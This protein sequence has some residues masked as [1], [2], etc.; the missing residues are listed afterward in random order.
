METDDVSQKFCEE[1][2][3]QILERRTRVVKHLDSGNVF[4]KA[5]FQVDEDIDDPDFWDNLLSKKK[6][7]ED[8][9]RV[10]RQMRR[11]ARDGD[12]HP[13]EIEEIDGLIRDMEYEICETVE[14]TKEISEELK[15][16]DSVEK[17]VGDDEGIEKDVSSDIPG[18]VTED[19]AHKNSADKSAEGKVTPL[20]QQS[21]SKSSSIDDLS[22]VPQQ[23]LLVF[24]TAL[25][26]GIPTINTLKNIKE[27]H[28]VISYVTKYC[29]EMTERGKVREDFSLHLE[30]L[31]KD[32]REIDRSYFEKYESVY[33]K[34]YERYLLRVQSI[35]IL[36][37]LIKHED[38]STMERG[39]GWTSEDDKRV[40]NWVTSNGYDNYP[41]S[42]G[43]EK[44]AFRGKSSHELN[45]RVR[46]IILTLNKKKDVKK[47]DS[48]IRGAILVFGKVTDE[49]RDNVRT[50]LG[51]D[52]SKMEEVE[53]MI[54]EALRENTDADLINRINLLS[55]LRELDD[56]P[57]LRRMAGLPRRW[58]VERDN[59]L[60]E[61]VIKEGLQE[62]IFN[63]FSAPGDVLVK[64]IEAMCRGVEK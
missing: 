22:S 50:F 13:E 18:I 39:R 8:E 24:L 1:D 10:K 38:I 61:A 42:T 26:K 36:S 52:N 32:T 12:L 53:R 19:D 47:D 28:R 23:H 60:R 44:G 17:V 41:T 21:I 30:S 49:N 46:K 45:Q 37:F 54:E 31:L 2:I 7:E 51:H 14:K 48:E 16:D 40:I 34:Y 63:R 6:S 43:S 33:K 55:R 56:M 27:P 57:T 9:G 20:G 4:S 35:M 5:S 62:K 29:I 58:S 3:D 64:R 59:E 15:D 25:R 11:L